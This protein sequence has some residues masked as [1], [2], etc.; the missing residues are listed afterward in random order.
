MRSDFALSPASPEEQTVQEAERGIRRW[1]VIGL[2]ILLSTFGL[3]VVWSTLVPI[4]SAV[5]APGIVKVETSRKKVQHQEG[6]VIREILVRDGD[7]VKAGQTLIR[8]DETRAGASHGILQSQYDAAI[9]QQARLVAERDLSQAIS[10]PEE[11]LARKDDPKVA[12]ILRSQE[13][14]FAARRASLI[15]QLEILDKQIAARQNQ[16]AGISGQRD[17]KEAQL[18]SL[19]IELGGLTDLLG[20]GM[21]EKTKYRTLEREIAQIAGERAELVSDIAVSRSAI[22]EKELEKFQ[23]RKGFHEEVVSELRK[24]QTEAF[25]YLERRGAA[26]Y[27]LSQT[28]LKASVDGVAVNLKTHTVGGVIAPGEVLLDIVPTNDR[29]II[30]AQVRPEDIDRVT[31]DLDTGVQLAA[32]DRRSTPEL[33]GRVRYISADAIEDPTTGRMYFL[34][35]VEVPESELARLGDQKKVQPGMLADVFMR[36]GERTF[37]DYLLHPIMASFDNAWRER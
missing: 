9:A 30:E 27:V 36:T 3:T 19:K 13:S 17:A 34:T 1:T 14:L 20:K 6:G 28:E 32:F 18:K 11:L 37:L 12:E 10:W 29:L 16:I 33:N 26:S 21:V 23:L 15:G 31:L 25:D 4:A 24:V 35:K 5:V 2:A 7:R 8:L 22:G